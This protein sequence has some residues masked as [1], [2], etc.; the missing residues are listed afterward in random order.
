MKEIIKLLI[1]HVVEGYEWYFLPKTESL[2]LINPDTRQWLLEYQNTGDLWYFLPRWSDFFKYI[3]MD[4]SEY[5]EY[6]I[7]YTED[8]LRN[9][10]RNTKELT[11]SF[12]FPTEDVLQNG[13]KR[14]TRNGNTWT[15]WA[16]DVL[17]NG[18]KL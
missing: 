5:K 12:T 10:V 1:D 3:N 6:L 2:W 17:Q 4:P 8:V 14:T 18:K 11:F 9:G 13:V 7:S 16:E 15:P